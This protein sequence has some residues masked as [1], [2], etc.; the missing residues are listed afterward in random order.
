ML[1]VMRETLNHPAIYQ[2][3]CSL[4]SHTTF[5]ACGACAVP[6][7]MLRHEDNNK[8]GLTFSWQRVLSHGT[9]PVTDPG[10]L[11]RAALDGIVL[12][13]LS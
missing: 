11:P 8:E 4:K 12:S 2:S 9:E 10:G 7:D 3:G 13:L 5:C 6:K 1:P